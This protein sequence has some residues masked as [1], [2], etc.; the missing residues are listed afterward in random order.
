V[1]DGQFCFAANGR[2]GA[3][4]YGSALSV[5]FERPRGKNDLGAIRLTTSARCEIETEEKNRY[6][7]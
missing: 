4:G 3:H 7:F 2:S 6:I 1:F 5:T